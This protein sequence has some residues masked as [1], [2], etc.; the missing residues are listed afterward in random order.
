MK[1]FNDVIKYM[2]KLVQFNFTLLK[3]IYNEKLL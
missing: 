3:R 1:I 2:T